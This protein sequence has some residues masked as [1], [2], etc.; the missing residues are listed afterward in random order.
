MTV[1][2]SMVED[3]DHT[4]IGKYHRY[5]LGYQ[6]SQVNAAKGKKHLDTWA[7]LMNDPVAKAAIQEMFM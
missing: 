4:N 7:K 5:I 6:S 1:E 2:M 3:Y